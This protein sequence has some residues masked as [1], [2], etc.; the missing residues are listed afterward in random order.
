MAALSIRLAVPVDLAF[1]LSGMK[2]IVAREKEFFNA[3]LQ[4]RLATKAIAAKKVRVALLNGKRVGFL[5]FDF[6]ESF[7]FGVAYGAYSSRYAWVSWAFVEKKFRGKGVGR[8]LYGDLQKICRKKKVKKIL[9]DVFEINGES[10]RFHTRIGFKPIV[11]IYEK[12]V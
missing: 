9:T 6:S 1:V 10:I 3:S 8:S 4:K 11:R 7:P 5:W 12:S 2:E